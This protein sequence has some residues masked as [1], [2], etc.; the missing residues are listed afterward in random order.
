MAS[1]L[2]VSGVEEYV[3]E[4]DRDITRAE[5]AAILVRGLGL[6]RPGVGQDRFN[7]VIKQNWYY[8]AVT[9]ASDYGLIFGYGNGKFGPNEPITREQA[10]AMIARAIQVTKPEV[11]LSGDEASTILAGYTDTSIAAD[12]AIP[13]KAACVKTGLIS[14]RDQNTLAPK[15]NITRAEVALIVQKL[16]QK[17]K[18]I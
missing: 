17:S 7:D 2:V 14:G 3:F 13:G 18:L 6:M 10:M 4:P 9:I 15:D 5:F 12:Y 1:R 11:N 16:L 8:D